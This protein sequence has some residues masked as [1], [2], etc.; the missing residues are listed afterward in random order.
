MSSDKKISMESTVKSFINEYK[1]FTEKNA[2]EKL[3]DSIN[4]IKTFYSLIFRYIIISSLIFA[5]S[6]V[7]IYFVSDSAKIAVTFFITSIPVIIGIGLLG[8]QKAVSNLVTGT[9][10][11]LDYI[12]ELVSLYYGEQ[13]K[14]GNKNMPSLLF[15]VQVV[16]SDLILP[17]ITDLVSGIF[18]SKLIIF[19]ISKA[20]QK[21]CN[22]LRKNDE[23]KPSKEIQF[24]SLDE[25][26]NENAVEVLSKINRIRNFMLEKSNSYLGKFKTLMGILS[27]LCIVLGIA[28]IVIVIIVSNLI[29]RFF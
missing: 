12:L 5:L 4:K 26:S 27:F 7:I 22:R 9:T 23:S 14:N 20:V 29:M 28:V 18:F 15:V 13:I 8:F 6:A 25:N 11:I 21:L 2:I 3:K 24:D 1:K 10:N 16:F 17:L 19:S